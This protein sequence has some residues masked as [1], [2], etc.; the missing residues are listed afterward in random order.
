MMNNLE[1]VADA[2]IST[3]QSKY[4]GSSMFFD[5]TGDYL[6]IPTA[7]AAKLSKFLTGNFTVEC[8][9]YLTTTGTSQHI[10][11]AVNNWAAGAN[12]NIRV[13][14]GNFLS[15]QIGNSITLIN[16]TV[17]FPLNQWNHIALVRTSTTNTVFYLNGVSVASTATN[18]TADEDCPVTI[19]CFNANGG[20]IGEYWTGYIDDVRI[21]NG[22]GRYTTNFNTS[23]P[24]EFE[25]Y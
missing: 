10:I 18:W 14:T 25:N 13:V 8:W 2:K 23:L 12:Y 19:G 11:S 22:V 20:S 15:V 7:Q 21:T 24:T 4:G 9:A 5:G 16:G 1:T 6:F 17:S 3:T